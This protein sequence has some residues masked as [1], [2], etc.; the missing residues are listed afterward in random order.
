[1]KDEGKPDT[2]TKR[3]GPSS[4]ISHPLV[5]RTFCAVA[6]PPPV[7]LQASE[8]IRKLKSLFPNVRARWTN[9]DS[10]HLTL[11]FIGDIPIGRVASLSR[12]AAKATILFA[13]FKLFVEGAGA[14]PS[15]G[16]A[17]VLWLGIG[18]Q[19]GGLAGLQ[20][21]LEEES[22][23]EGFANEERPFHP[24]LT[25][26][27]IREPRGAHPLIAKH[28]ELGFSAVAAAVTELLV[29]RSELSSAGSKYTVLSRH[30]L[31]GTG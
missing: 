21:R 24:H 18:D 3:N 23:K 17:K 20:K 13:P 30:S 1:M 4:L 6:L 7:C 28:K 19:E 31:T 5:W 27:R 22:E 11:K 2:R 16:P 25:L 14:F 9:E 29:M 15:S 8:H 12:A 26:A 10:F